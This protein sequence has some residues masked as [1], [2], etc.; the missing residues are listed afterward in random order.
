MPS[1]CGA[2][3]G[4]WKSLGQQGDWTSQSKEGDQPW[5]FTGRAD[6]ES[7]ALVFWSSDVNRWLIGKVPDA[8]KDWEQKERVSEDERAGQ[9]HWCNEHEL[10]Q[11]PGDGEG[12]GGLVCCS[13]WGR[14]ESDTTGQLNHS[15]RTT[16]IEQN[17]TPSPQKK[18][19]T[20]D[21]EPIKNRDFFFFNES[22][23]TGYFIHLFMFL[24]RHLRS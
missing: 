11:T 8:G 6:A 15:N 19:K 23:G 14:K 9:H 4:S 1:N 2:G 12:Q 3:E 7:E 5:I 17:W 20:W 22:L 13:P 16:T 10:G 24:A 21:V 18:K